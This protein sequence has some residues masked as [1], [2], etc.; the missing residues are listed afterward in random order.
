MSSVPFATADDVADRWRPL[1][2]SEES[3]AETLVGDASRIMRARYVGIDD[4]I[5]AGTLDPQAATQ[6]A[7][8]MVRRALI[9]PFEGVDQQTETAGPYSHSQHYLNAAR[10]LFLTAVDDLLIRGYRPRARSIR[11]AC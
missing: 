8:G 10:N 2:D 5:T 3:I 9:A 11:Y 6:V 4:W 1:T 7:A